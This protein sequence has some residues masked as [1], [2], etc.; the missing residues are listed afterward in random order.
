MSEQFKRLNRELVY[1][2][3]VVDFYEETLMLLVAFLS[4]R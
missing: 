4:P 1:H 2:G 3:H